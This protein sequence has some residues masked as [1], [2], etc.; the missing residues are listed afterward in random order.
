[1]SNRK[2]SRAQSGESA[3]FRTPPKKDWRILPTL[4]A[5]DAPEACA[6]PLSSVALSLASSSMVSVGWGFFI[7]SLSMWQCLHA[8][9]Q[10]SCAHM[11]L[12][13]AGQGWGKQG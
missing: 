12:R 7:F 8:L 6:A 9:G 10:F 2:S 1:M 13:H 5:A 3:N 11:Y 4:E